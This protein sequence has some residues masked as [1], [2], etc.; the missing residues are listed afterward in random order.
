MCAWFDCDDVTLETHVKAHYGLPFKEVFARKRG[1]GKVSL[2]RRQFQA[3]LE[4][5]TSMMIFLGKQY[6][7]QADKKEIKGSW[8]NPYENLSDE[9]LDKRYAELKQK[10]NEEIKCLPAREV[11]EVEPITDTEGGANITELTKA[12]KA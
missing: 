1:K 12:R 11:V 4:G 10:E 8:Q 2:R 7:D 5:D 9:E 3:A 6:L